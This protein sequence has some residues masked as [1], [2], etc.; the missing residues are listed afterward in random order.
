MKEG[1]LNFSLE[2]W[3][4]VLFSASFEPEVTKAAKQCLARYLHKNP[5][6]KEDTL[7]TTIE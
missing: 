7:Q 1:V 4:A 3:T 6:V 2:E 5:W